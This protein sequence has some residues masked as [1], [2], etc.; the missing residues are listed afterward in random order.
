MRRTLFVRSLFLTGLVV[1]VGAMGLIATPARAQG[2]GAIRGV[3]VDEAG[4]PVAGAV[5]SLEYIGDYVL[6]AELK[7]NDKGEFLK[8]GLHPGRW[9]IAAKKDDLFGSLAQASV[10][11]GNTPP[12][13]TIIM[14]KGGPAA[15]VKA[16]ANMSQAEVDKRNKRQGE[17][18]TMVTTAAADIDAFPPQDPAQLTDATAKL[19]DAITKLITVASEIPTGCAACYLKIG[20]AYEK[21]KDDAKAEE[22]YKKV[23]D[24]DATKGEGYSALATLYNRQKKFE[25]AG[26]MSAKATELLGGGGGILGGGGGGGDAVS[27]YNSGIILWNQS[28]A[29]EAQVL[30]EKAIALDPKM[31]DAHYFLGMTLVNQNK[32]KEAKVPFEAYM[33]LA[34]TGKYADQVKGLLDVIK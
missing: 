8:V 17:L 29:A 15:T 33:K 7:T 18:E 30:F 10:P 4:K 21:K 27:T 3:C 2:T 9:K 6:T 16:G 5:L 34:P 25:L 23:I 24:L 22:S 13:I 12:P 31:A 14:K 28:K 1:A 19:D 11:L 26:Q 20:E 32:L